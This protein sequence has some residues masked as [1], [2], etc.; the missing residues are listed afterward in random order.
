LQMRWQR[1]R[2][3]PMMRWKLLA[4]A[5][6]FL[7]KGERVYPLPSLIFFIIFNHFFKLLFLPHYL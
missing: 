5:K 6:H 1:H 3:L 2:P 7:L 4:T